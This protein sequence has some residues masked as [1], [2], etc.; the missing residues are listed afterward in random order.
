MFGQQYRFPPYNPFEASQLKG[1]KL[2]TVLKFL[3]WANKR[4]QS[5][6]FTPDGRQSGFPLYGFRASSVYFL[7]DIFEFQNAKLAEPLGF[8]QRIWAL[9][10]T[11]VLPDGSD[12]IGE[13]ICLRFEMNGMFLL[14]RL[15]SLL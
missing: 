11:Y 9:L 7:E 5:K 15:L 6:R 13:F 12:S 4:L 1:D 8:V 2:P 10:S 14:T 3:K